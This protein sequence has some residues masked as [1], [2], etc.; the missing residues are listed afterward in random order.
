MNRLSQRFESLRARGEKCLVPF[1]TAAYPSLD[2]SIALLKRLTNPR[3]GAIEIGFPFS[4]PVADGPVIQTSFQRALEN[5]FRVSKLFDAL[6]AARRDIATPLIAMVS[7]SIVFARGVEAFATD[8]SQAGFDGLLVPDLSLEE[9]EIVVAACKPRGLSLVMI[10]APTSD[11]ARRERIC[12]ISEPFVY[13][14]AV[15]GITGERSA[16]PPDLASRVATVRDSGK[17]VC[18]GFGISAP[19]QVREVCAIADGAIVGSAI[20]RRINDAIDAGQAEASIVDS[21][22]GFVDELASGAA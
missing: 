12:S 18:V 16:L 22:V 10:C 19:P 3:I 17:A 9:C 21:V 15:A 13:Y 2:A 11:A 7:Y 4:D 20:V 1:L 6:K 14:Q 5:G 8:A